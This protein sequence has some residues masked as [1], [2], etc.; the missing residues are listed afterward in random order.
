MHLGWLKRWSVA[1]YK[2]AV[3]TFF[4]SID[5]HNWPAYHTL[6]RTRTHTRM[7]ERTQTHKKSLQ[8]P[9]KTQLLSRCL[10]TTQVLEFCTGKFLSKFSYKHSWVFDCQADVASHSH[11]WWMHVRTHT[12]THKLLSAVRSQLCET[13]LLPPSELALGCLC[14]NQAL[15]FS[16]GK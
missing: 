5:A 10:C 9:F 8:Q 6:T 15:K 13:Q 11:A 2:C 4:P 7:H 3:R 12:N 1:L 16:A 14:T